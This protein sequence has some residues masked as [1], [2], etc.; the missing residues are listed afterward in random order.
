MSFI[1]RRCTKGQCRHKGLACPQDSDINVSLRWRTVNLTQNKNITQGNKPFS[2]YFCST[3]PPQSPNA[4]SIP[5]LP[6]CFDCTYTLIHLLADEEN[7]ATIKVWLTSER[8]TNLTGS[9][10]QKSTMLPC[11]TY[12]D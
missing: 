4:L 11:F 10:K 12:Y 8:I 2:K 7:L 1:V 6:Y 9:Y 3:L 5:A